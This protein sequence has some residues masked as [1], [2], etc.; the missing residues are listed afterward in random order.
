MSFKRKIQYAQSGEQSANSIYR[1]VLAQ[2]LDTSL[3]GYSKLNAVTALLSILNSL[4][5]NGD[6]RTSLA[7]IPKFYTDYQDNPMLRSAMARHLYRAIEP[8]LAE[9]KLRLNNLAS[10]CQ[11]WQR[12]WMHHRWQDL[13]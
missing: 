13:G 4:P 5:E 12:Y 10:R 9:E 8:L 1:R 6:L 3:P 11:C 7:T 2:R